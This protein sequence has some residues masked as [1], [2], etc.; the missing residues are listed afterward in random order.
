MPLKLAAPVQG[1]STAPFDPWGLPLVNTLILLT[2]GTT[3]TW[4]HHA[5]LKNNRKGSYGVWC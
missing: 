1:S 2:S 3:V 4:A 5:L